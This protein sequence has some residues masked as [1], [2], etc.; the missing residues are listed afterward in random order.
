MSLHSRILALACTVATVF[1]GEARRD[2]ALPMVDLT[3]QAT[4]FTTVERRKS[5]LGHPSTVRFRDGQTVLV[6]YPDGHG[7]GNL[8]LRRSPDAGRRGNRWRS[9]PNGS[10]K[11]RRFTASTSPLA[12]SACSW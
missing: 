11:P 1:A 4:G 10:R 9:P 7:K 5:Y 3:K 8:I 6:A 12:A 2:Y